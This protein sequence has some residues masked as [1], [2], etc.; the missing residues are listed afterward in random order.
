MA[1][2]AVKQINNLVSA[3]CDLSVKLHY[4]FSIV[5]I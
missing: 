5:K 2:A 1:S 4:P 3:L